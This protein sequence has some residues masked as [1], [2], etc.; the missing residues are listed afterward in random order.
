MAATHGLSVV[1][2]VFHRYTTQRSAG[3]LRTSWRAWAAGLR[4]SLAL[5]GLVTLPGRPVLAQT[6]QPGTEAGM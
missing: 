3:V 4:R 6:G 5:G 1:F 2:A